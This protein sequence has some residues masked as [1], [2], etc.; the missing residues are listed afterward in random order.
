MT[1]LPTCGFASVSSRRSGRTALNSQFRSRSTLCRNSESVTDCPARA[2]AAL[3]GAS[4][5]RRSRSEGLIRS[6]FDSAIAVGLSVQFDK[7]RFQN[8]RLAG[9]SGQHALADADVRLRAEVL[10]L[11]LA[12][13]PNVVVLSGLA[14]RVAGREEGDL[15]AAVL[16]SQLCRGP[17]EIAQIRRRLHLDARETLERYP[18]VLA[19]QDRL[20]D[21]PEPHIGIPDPLERRA[22]QAS[23]H[24]SRRVERGGAQGGRLLD[25]SFA[26]EAK[27]LGE[28]RD[29]LGRLTEDERRP[30]A[31]E[32]VL[33]EELAADHLAI[34]PHEVLRLDVHLVDHTELRESAVPLPAQD[35]ELEEHDAALGV[36]R[37][38]ADRVLALGE[39]V[40]EPPR[41]VRQ[42]PQ[43]QGRRHL[44]GTPPSS[45]RL[46][47][48]NV[49]AALNPR[50]Q[51]AV[52]LLLL[53]VDLD[54]AEVEAYLLDRIVIAPGATTLHARD[55]HIGQLDGH[56]CRRRPVAA[57]RN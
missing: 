18:V 11:G 46:A 12:T 28:P 7:A 36:R 22:V 48:L 13:Q 43:L 33:A 39:Q 26:K 4:S 50:A 34:G 3:P 16:E 23:G 19:V 29:P 45:G 9:V 49:P 14:S 54:L 42:L 32:D 15:L 52:L 44:R 8:R 38:A 57:A 24:H 56:V 6:R 35:E 1:E 51:R 55:E 20:A 17:D 41:A 5:V 31:R 10:P 40:H 30:R 53:V 37:L 25:P 27:G 21:G 47:L 2:E